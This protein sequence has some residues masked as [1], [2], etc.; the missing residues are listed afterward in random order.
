VIPI[1]I[2]VTVVAGIL[3]ATYY[4]RAPTAPRDR[5]EA[6]KDDGGSATGWNDGGSDG[7]GSCGGDGGGCD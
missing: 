7:D 4:F 3:A 6:G 2:G 1:L 5:R